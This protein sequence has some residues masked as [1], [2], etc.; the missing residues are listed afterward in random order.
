MIII[1]FDQQAQERFKE[2]CTT[3]EPRLGQSGDLSDLEG[4]GAKLSGHVA[5]LAGLLHLAAG[6]SVLAQVSVQTLERAIT[7]GDYLIGE[8]KA[9]LDLMGADED[10]AGARH[11]LKWIQSNEMSE[12]SRSRAQ[13]ENRAR[14]ERADDID[15]AIQILQSNGWI[16]VIDESEGESRAPGRPKSPRFEVNPR[17]RCIGELAETG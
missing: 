13:Q 14:F 12:F 16:R 8:A 15:P 11:L 6:S 10:L 7:L 5:R 3:I 1:A 17:A 4:W 2:Y 9:T